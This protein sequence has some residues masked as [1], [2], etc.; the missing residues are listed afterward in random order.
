MPYTA[1]IKRT[2]EVSFELV[3]HAENPQEALEFCEFAD[4]DENLWWVYEEIEITD[5]SGA[6]VATK[7]IVLQ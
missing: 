1:K 3:D 4:I 6:I 7:G 5:E 2:L